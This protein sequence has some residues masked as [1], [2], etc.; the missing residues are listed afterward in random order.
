MPY[1]FGF[2]ME[3]TLGQ[4]THTKNFQQWVARDPDIVPT[5]FPISYEERSGLAR[6]PVL[7]RNWTIRASL[8]ARDQVRTALRAQ[9]FDALFFHT[10]VTALFAHRL[11]REVP[12]I[13]SMD[14]T[15]LNFDTIGK[16]Y[17]HSTSP[18]KSVES[19][20]NALTR[21]SF[22]RAQCLVVWHEWGKA[23]LVQDYGAPAEKVSVIPPGVDLE[24]WNFPRPAERSSGP[25]RLLF[26]GGDFSRK[27]GEALL[28][29]MHQGLAA[30]CELDI[31]TKGP[32]DTAGLAGVRVHNGLGPNAPALMAL[33]RSADIFVFPTLA[34]V[35]PLAIME[36]MAS[37]LPVITTD[38]GAIREQV[39]DGVTGSLIP[40]NDVDAL[41]RTTMRV[42]ENPELRHSM[43]AAARAAAER[44]FNGSRNYP[45]ILELMKRCAD[46]ATGTRG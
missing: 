30:S 11:M 28:A 6:L 14:A 1:R 42:V 29:A 36:A 33:Y 45:Q 39:E 27:G 22:N 21:R 16:P 43:G 37:G 4:V 25:V 12:S 46:Q 17:A 31:V 10:Q 8:Q 40:P 41:C 2:V 35:L 32:V 20:K 24:L 38:V 3:Q 26:V 15:P 23:S 18:V 19:L 5:W 7:G 44:L 34:D 13:V 9:T